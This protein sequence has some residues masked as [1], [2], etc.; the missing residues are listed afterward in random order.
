MLDLVLSPPAQERPTH[1]REPST[2]PPRC[3]RAWSSCAG[4]RGCESWGCLIQSRGSSGGP[5][6]TIN[7]HRRF[8]GMGLCSVVPGAVQG[9]RAVPWHR[10]QREVGILVTLIWGE[11]LE[12]RENVHPLLLTCTVNYWFC[13]VFFP[14]CRSALLFQPY[15]CL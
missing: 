12:R 2:G 8:K 13:F 11:E 5:T 14:L 4:W 7:P 10:E 9:H 15:S 1:W 3:S 6:T